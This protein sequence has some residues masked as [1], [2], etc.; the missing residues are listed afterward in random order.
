MRL[1]NAEILAR[2]RIR[3]VR[4]FDPDW[5]PRP[6]IVE[7]A[8]GAIRRAEGEAREAEARIREIFRDS[9]PSTNPE[10]GAKRLTD[11]LRNRGYV[12]RGPAKKSPG[13]RYVDPRTGDEV[14]IMERPQTR[15]KS[16]A[17]QKHL[18]D[19]YY[20]YKPGAPKNA[21]WGSH[22]PIPNKKSGR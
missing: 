6:S 15:R 22:V 17:A 8:E 21:P 12:Y 3:K 16:E 7:T 5:S 4:K 10:W 19:F 2:D 9:V 18:Y 14:R 13:Q 11:E 20:R 1:N